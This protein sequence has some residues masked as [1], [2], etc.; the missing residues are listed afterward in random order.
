MDEISIS[1]CKF[2]FAFYILGEN[3]YNKTKQIL[4]LLFLLKEKFIHK[5]LLKKGRKTCLSRLSHNLSKYRDHCHGL[6]QLK[7]ETGLNSKYQK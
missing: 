7:T 1:K 6:L 2:L 4:E 3:I 5:Y